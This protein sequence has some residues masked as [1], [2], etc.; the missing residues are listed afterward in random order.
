MVVVIICIDNCRTDWLL[1]HN[2]SVLLD[3]Y[4]SQRFFDNALYHTAC[5]LSTSFLTTS[6]RLQQFSSPA[7]SAAGETSE[8]PSSPTS[9]RGRSSQSS[10]NLSSPLPAH[11]R[12]GR[13]TW[14]LDTDLSPTRT[15]TL[16][17]APSPSALQD[18]SSQ[19]AQS[20]RKNLFLKASSN[21]ALKTHRILSESWNLL[22]YS[23]R[24]W[25]CNYCKCSKGWKARKLKVSQR[26]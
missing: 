19:N 12:S 18:N 10:S 21:V 4:M 15:S 7:N 6:R 24:R 14:S 20:S 8:A 26:S 1:Q 17:S 16:T 25:L 22:F 9:P 2:E 5:L 23:E 11:T 3:E 13:Q